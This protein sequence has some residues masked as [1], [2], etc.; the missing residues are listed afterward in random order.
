MGNKPSV[1]EFKEVGGGKRKNTTTAM[2]YTTARAS[3]LSDSICQGMKN[4]LQCDV[5]CIHGGAMARLADYIRHG[6]LDVREYQLLVIHLATNDVTSR[7][8]FTSCAAKIVAGLDRAVYTI[9]QINPSVRL[10]VSGTLPRLVDHVNADWDMINARVYSNVA[11]RDFCDNHGLFYIT[12][13][14]MLNGHDPFDMYRPADGL[15]LS[16]TGTFYFQQYMEGKIGEL[17]GPDPRRH[18][19]IA[20][21]PNSRW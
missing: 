8:H 20:V 3:I 7:V 11:L 1:K 21:L 17:L 5:Q 9:Q 14:T 4:L 10:A 16:P 15:H 2:G 19:P 6:V 13:E 12:S 18:R